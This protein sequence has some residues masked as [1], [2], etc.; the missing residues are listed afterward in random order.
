MP[1]KN[2]IET[3]PPP[4]G[5]NP[6]NTDHESY[7]RNLPEL[8]TL[9]RWPAFQDICTSLAPPNLLFLKQETYAVQIKAPTMNPNSVASASVGC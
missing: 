1:I 3:S 5:H 4:K 6:E 2:K 8:V 9:S 7:A